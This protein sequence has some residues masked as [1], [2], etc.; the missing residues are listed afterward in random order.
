VPD[1]GPYATAL[2]REPALVTALMTLVGGFVAQAGPGHVAGLKALGTSVTVSGLQGVLTRQRVYSPASVEAGV[3][4]RVLASPTTWLAQGAEPALLTA[5]VGLFAGFLLQVVGGSTDLLQALGISAGLAGTQGALTRQVVYSP[6]SAALTALAP[7][8][9]LGGLPTADGGAPAPAGG[10]TAPPPPAPAAAPEPPP[11]PPA[12]PGPPPPPPPPAPLASPQPDMAA[13]PDLVALLER[14]RPEVRYDSLESYFA[15]WAAVITNR[16]GNVL[17]RQD[18]TVIATAGASAAPLTLEFLQPTHYPNGLVVDA[19]DYVDEVGNDYEVQARKMHAQPAYANKVHGR[20][21]LD[22]SGARWLQYWFFYYYDDPGF[23]GFGTHEGDIEMIQ[24]RLDARGQPDAVSYSQ[25]RSGLRAAWNQVELTE[26]PDGPVPVT[27]S[28]RGSHAN[29]LRFGQQVSARSFLPDHNDGL[30]PRI[31][32]DLVVL[33]DAATP[34][35]LWPGRWGGTHAGELFGN[36]GI[37]VNSPLALI[38][39]TAWNDPAG[40]HAGCDMAD[41]PPVGQPALLAAPGPPAPMLTTRASATGTVVQVDVPPAPDRPTATKVVVGLVPT[42][43]PMPAITRTVNLRGPAETVELPDPP[44]D[45]TY[46]V[47]AT[48]QS[49]T[50]MTSETMHAA[51]PA[52]GSGGSP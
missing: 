48:T 12:A 21:V 29:L 49:D 20:V 5:F 38:A 40:F 13:A 22:G 46:E 3:P 34:W 11:P 8:I 1:A 45:A 32:P 37:S 9:D 17:K 4:A 16:P 7:G 27:Y 30:G 28:A 19:T 36:L 35:S 2:K 50:G 39:H 26:S 42:D 47:R 23:L 25:H 10:P 33:S 51:M 43:A 52:P 6:R 24:L 41:V 18:G 44:D 31:R 14:F 15:D